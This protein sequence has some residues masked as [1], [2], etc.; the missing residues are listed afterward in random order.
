MFVPCAFALCEQCMQRI[1]LKMFRSSCFRLFIF[2]GVEM[3]EL[4][5]REAPGRDSC[6]G[7]A[8]T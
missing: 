3:V 4:S 8:V 1:D 5:V 2:I 7:D 6:C